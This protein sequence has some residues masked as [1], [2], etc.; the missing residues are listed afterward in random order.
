VQ[1]YDKPSYSL[2][3]YLFCNSW[4][5]N[6]IY[7]RRVM[8]T[9]SE[10]ASRHPRAAAAA[11]ISLI[12]LLGTLSLTLTVHRANSGHM[13]VVIIYRDLYYS[14]NALS[15]QNT[16]VIELYSMLDKD[17]T[18]LTWYNSGIGTYAQPSWKSLAYWTLVIHSYIDLAI[19]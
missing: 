18:Q 8:L 16:N 13:Y 3:N 10:L 14:W 19:A 4:R 7:F 1:T 2:D 15:H 12:P 5:R 17:D 9:I 11:T 6:L